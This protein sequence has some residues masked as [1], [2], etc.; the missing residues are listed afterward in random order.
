MDYEPL[1]VQLLES[2][3][4]RV[5]GHSRVKSCANAVEA[6]SLLQHKPVALLFLY[7]QMPQITGL[8][9]IKSPKHRPQ[10]ILTTAYREYAPEAYDPDIAD[11]L[12][13]LIL[14]DHFLR[15]L[16]RVYRHN[17]PIELPPAA[18]LLLHA[19]PKAYIY[20]K[21][22]L[23]IESLHAYVRIRLAPGRSSLT[24]RSFT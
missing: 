14:F 7:I 12:L 6:F 3:V 8:K 10:V 15:A 11:Y 4:K 24:K 20:L 1:A 19:Y 9:L 2:Y 18:N 23:Y 17:H 21:D 5:Q 16:A 22:I 13:K